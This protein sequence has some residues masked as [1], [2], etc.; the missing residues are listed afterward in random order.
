MMKSH[1]SEKKV[2]QPTRRTVHLPK[3]DE[4]SFFNQRGNLNLEND[5]ASHR[6]YTWMFE[7]LLQ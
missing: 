2:P 3:R 7:D 5:T 6:R 1:D 4:A